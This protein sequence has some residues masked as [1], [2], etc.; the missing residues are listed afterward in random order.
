MKKMRPNHKESK[1][2][3]DTSLVRTA[4]FNPETAD[5]RRQWRIPV[6]VPVI[7]AVVLQAFLLVPANAIDPVTSPTVSAKTDV[8]ATSRIEQ[9]RASI[10]TLPRKTVEAPAI[11]PAF[12]AGD[13]MVLGGKVEPHADC[14][15]SKQKCVVGAGAVCID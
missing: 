6:G 14:N 15:P 4:S 11:L 2:M 12:S 5:D 1:N 7:L 10:K 8:T 3:I 13:C 9:L